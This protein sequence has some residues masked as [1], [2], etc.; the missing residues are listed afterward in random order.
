MRADNI[1]PGFW[2]KNTFMI[3]QT[4]LKMQHNDEAKVWLEKTLASPSKTDEDKQV[5]KEAEALKVKSGL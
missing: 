3:A 1:S 4:Y 2:K 5:Q